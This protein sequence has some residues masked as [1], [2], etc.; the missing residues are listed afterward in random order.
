MSCEGGGS[1]GPASEENV[2]WL[3]RAA[4]LEET[5]VMDREAW[6]A[7]SRLYEVFVVRDIQREGTPGEWG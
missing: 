7:L 4:G 3:Q 6:D 1:H 5:G 2:R